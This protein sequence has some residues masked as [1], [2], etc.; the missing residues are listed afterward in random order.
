MQ[1]IAR[2]LQCRSISKA[3]DNITFIIIGISGRPIC[4]IIRRI[5][6]RM[7][8]I[9]IKNHI[10][11]GDIFQLGERLHFIQNSLRQFYL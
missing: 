1:G 8:N 5:R 9:L 7:K 6:I 2:L 11:T 4:Q 3:C 10:R